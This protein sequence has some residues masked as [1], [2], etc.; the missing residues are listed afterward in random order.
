MSKYFIL[1][2]KGVLLEFNNSCNNIQAAWAFFKISPFMFHGRNSYRRFGKRMC[3]WQHLI[4]LWISSL[5]Y[6][7][8][9]CTSCNWHLCYVQSDRIWD[10]GFISASLY[11]AWPDSTACVS[12]CLHTLIRQRSFNAHILTHKHINKQYLRV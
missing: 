1:Y 10:H 6:S 11:A 5:Q 2:F 12:V 9:L 8:S 7:L 4:S 3:K